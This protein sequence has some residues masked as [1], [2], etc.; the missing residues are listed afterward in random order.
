M[1]SRGPTAIHK[2]RRSGS[3][4]TEQ[5]QETWATLDG[6]LHI[7]ASSVSRTM[8]HVDAAPGANPSPAGNRAAALSAGHRAAARGGF[9]LGLFKEPH[10]GLKFLVPFVNEKFFHEQMSHTLHSVLP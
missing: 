8:H 2:L 10:L 3:A 5:F 6:L 7:E 1:M 4:G 9:R